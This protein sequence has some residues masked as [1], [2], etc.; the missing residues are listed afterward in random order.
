MFMPH[1][2]MENR[3]CGEVLT[4][5]SAT[6]SGFQPVAGAAEGR[7]GSLRFVHRTCRS[8]LTRIQLYDGP[9]PRLIEGLSSPMRPRG[10]LSERRIGYCQ[11]VISKL[12]LIII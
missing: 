8:G 2:L 10:G 7:T 1:A 12:P 5:A 4:W 9:R 3:N 6:L 11:H